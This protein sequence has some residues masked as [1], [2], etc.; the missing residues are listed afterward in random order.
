MSSQADPVFG[1]SE[2]SLLR[3]F[4]LGEI[5]MGHG[6]LQEA[7]RRNP[8]L[9]RE[10]EGIARIQEALESDS[11]NLGMEPR[12]DS[13]GSTRRR[14]G[15]S[16][17]RKGRGGSGPLRVIPWVAA[18]AALVLALGLGLGDPMGH[19]RSD[20]DP[21]PTFLSGDSEISIASDPSGAAEF[22]TWTPAS[23]PMARYVVRLFEEGTGAPVLGPVETKSP[24]LRI[25]DALL[26]STAGEFRA[27]IRVEGAGGVTLDTFE[28]CFSR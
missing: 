7:F 23:Q 11:R 26:G 25:T 14:R 24:R 1:A 3:R 17:D 28:A 20:T 8:A 2:E 6:V 5:R 27:V 9:R 13:D 21:A 10:C 12:L 22:L 18:A 15:G 4:V 16:R 19:R